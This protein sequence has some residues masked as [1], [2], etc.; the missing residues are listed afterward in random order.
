MTYGTAENI[1]AIEDA[2]IH[3]YIPIAERGQRTG[4]YGLADFTY[5]P[6]HDHYTCPQG[7]FLIPFHREE[8]TQV[9]EYRAVAGTCN[10]CPVKAACTTNKR[11]RH[12]HR[13][14]FADYL[15]RVKAY[16]LTLAYHKARNSR[17][18]WIEPLFGE[19]KQ[20]HGMRRFRL[21][22]LWRVNGFALVIASG[23]NLKRLRPQA[24]V[25]TTSVS[26]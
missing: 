13:S 7:Q 12:I 14:F 16:E 19:G 2:H 5:D 9:V 25:G 4:Y 20:W 23:Q 24:R 26:D 22:R 6:V 11:G 15:E 21:R 3:A 18:V 1:K 8:Q 17:K 10:V